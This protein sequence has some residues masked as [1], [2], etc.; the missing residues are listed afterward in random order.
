M[1]M[2]DP[3]TVLIVDDDPNTCETIGDILATQGFGIEIASGGRAALERLGSRAIDAAI[4]DMRLPDVSGLDL[5]TQIK[6]SSPPTEVIVITGYASLPSAIQAIE[7]EAFAYLQKPVEMEQLLATLRRALERRRLTEALHR[8][9]ER[10]RLV[11]ESVSDAVFL[12]DLQGRPILVNSR[13]TALTGYSLEELQERPI[14]P[15]L[16][17]GA[18][19]EIRRQLAAPPGE[20]PIVFET[21]I[22]KKDGCQVWVEASL[23]SVVKEGRIVGRLGIARDITERKHLEDQLRQA[24]KLEAVGRLAGSIA[25]DFNNLLTVIGGRTH[26]LGWRLAP[27]DPVRHDVEIIEQTAERAAALTRQLLAFS[28]KQVLAP[29]VLELSAVVTGMGRI[30]RRLIGEDIDLVTRTG[31]GRVRVDPSQIEQVL[32]NLAINSRDAMP[33]GGTLVIETGLVDLDAEYAHGHAGAEPG[34]YVLLAVTDTGHGMDEATRAQLFVPFFTTKEPGKGTG[35]GLATV[36]GIVKQSG[37]HIWVYS[38]VGHGSTFKIYLPRA[39][40][41]TDAV[42]GGRPAEALLRGT[43]IVLLAEDDDGVRLLAREALERS[44]Y[45]VLEAGHPDAAYEIA[46]DH[47]EGIDLL[48]TDLVMPG[49]SGRALAARIKPLRPGLK[50]LFMSGY[51]ADASVQH[52]IL[53]GRVAFLQKPF[54]PGGLARRVREV[55]DAKDE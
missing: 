42:V 23:S 17:P 50:V 33:S 10:Y 13:V 31:P 53:D 52:G 26:I 21:A 32:L 19:A 7:H 22:T 9:E 30:L 28:R 39:D 38:E 29:Q 45:T 12:L 35:L 5:L 16:I 40:E 47:R 36:Y 2:N 14:V 34:P 41:T 27:D 25:H 44:G 48:L 55:L 8:S 18:S 3:A 20:T 37:G 4:V 43:E 51:T 46:R 54:T 11:T 1:I 15:L 6:H 24:Q 49:M